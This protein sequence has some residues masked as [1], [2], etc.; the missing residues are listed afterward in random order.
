M[1]ETNT[2]VV[3]AREG[4]S[5]EQACEARAKAWAYILSC[6]EKNGAALTTAPDDVRG[7]LGAHTANGS[8]Q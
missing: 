3:R 1:S 8:I 7:D 4:V 6:Y 5:P 2:V